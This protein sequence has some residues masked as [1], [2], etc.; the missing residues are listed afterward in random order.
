MFFKRM[1][2]N[3]TWIESLKNENYDLI[4]TDIV[5]DCV[6]FASLLEVPIFIRV[7]T[8]P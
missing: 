7:G 5:H 1:M 8:V 3:E 4:L 6:V 2:I